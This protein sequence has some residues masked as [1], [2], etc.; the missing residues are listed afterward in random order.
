MIRFILKCSTLKNVNF[1]KL[2]TAIYTRIFAKSYSLIIGNGY[3]NRF[4]AADH[5]LF[6]QEPY[7]RWWR[8]PVFARFRSR[9]LLDGSLYS[10]VLNCCYIFVLIWVLNKYIWYIKFCL[11]CNEIICFICHIVS[12]LT[13][14]VIAVFWFCY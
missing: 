1:L 5:V 9:L 13:C 3:S 10:H 8:S 7:F 6:L 12:L 11:F 4:Q 2:A 14:K